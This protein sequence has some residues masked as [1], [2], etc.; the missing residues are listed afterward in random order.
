MFNDAS[1]VYTSKVRM[2]F[3]SVGYLVFAAESWHGQTNTARIYDVV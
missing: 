2:T 3:T 1:V